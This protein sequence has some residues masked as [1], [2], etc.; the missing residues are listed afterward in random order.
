MK[1]TEIKEGYIE[2]NSAKDEK[3]GDNNKEGKSDEA[4]K[5]MKIMK[6]GTQKV[7]DSK[8]RKYEVPNNKLSEAGNRRKVS[9]CEATNLSRNHQRSVQKSIEAYLEEDNKKKNIEEKKEEGNN[10][11]DSKEREKEKSVNQ[12]D[13]IN[14]QKKI[15]KTY[16]NT[17]KKSIKHKITKSTSIAGSPEVKFKKIKEYFN[18]ENTNIPKYKGNVKTKVKLFEDTKCSGDKVSGNPGIGNPVGSAKDQLN[19]FSVFSN[20][21]STHVKVNQLEDDI[22][23]CGGTSV[24]LQTLTNPD[25]KS[26]TRRIRDQ[27]SS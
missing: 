1:R 3:D 16:K 14:V 24:K 18:L 17:P 26:D 19:K 12:N 25:V 8:Y 13:L 6:P 11:K 7:P 21:N 9:S 27:E 10:C 22:S 5:I 15:L 23:Y 4:K 2:D 20:M